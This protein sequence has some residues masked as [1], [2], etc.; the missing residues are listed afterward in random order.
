VRLKKT[1]LTSA[2]V[3]AL[4]ITLGAAS[5][6]AE[7]KP[8]AGTQGAAP[9]VA[10]DV[11]A[12]KAAPA[13]SQAVS[14][15]SF[16]IQN[17]IVSYVQANGTRSTFGAYVD[18]SI[19]KVVLETDAPGDVVNALV[20]SFG[21]MVEVRKQTITDD[22]S[23]K[24]DTPSFWGGA[25]VTPSV[26]TPWCTDGYVVQNSAGT[27]FMV[28]AGHCFSNGQTAVTEN[29]GLTVGVASGNGLSVGQDMVLLSGQSYSPSIYTGGVDDSV[30]A[31]IASAA[32][33][34]V[35]FNNYCT[36]GRTT[37][38]NC[39]HTD[40]DNNATVCTQTGCKSPVIAY[41]GGNLPQGG[42]SGAPFYVN[43]I[44]APDMHIRGHHIAGGG[45]TSFAELFS[46]VANRFGVSIVT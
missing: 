10:A 22:F 38:A 4:A 19:G 17:R 7:G 16:T 37:G 42:D 36:S 27:R 13:V 11:A 33:P 18:R 5:A 14:Q 31:H 25:G 45:G 46:R 8:N 44:G 40:L 26:G 34:V 1:I 23:R 32:D 12:G 6:N 15:A 24:S 28:D 2:V 30:N 9:A 41:N 20:G 43:S 39:G 3:A 29:G 35:G 21:G